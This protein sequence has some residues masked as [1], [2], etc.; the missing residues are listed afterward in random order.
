MYI[1]HVSIACPIYYTV[2][3]EKSDSWLNI[4][5]TSFTYA[6][7]NSGPRKL[8]CGS[9]VVTLT[10]SNNCPPS[11]TLCV[12][13]S[14]NSLIHT[15]ALGSTPEA[16]IFLSSR[17][18]GTKSKAFEKSIIIASILPPLSRES[19]MSRQTVITS[20]TKI[21]TGIRVDLRISS[22]S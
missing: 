3:C 11:R 15:T 22:P 7:N 1:L 6:T 2:V 14:R 21:P 4:F 18:W 19:A 12:R 9:P 16:A 5:Q 20:L 13:P 17:S 8:P 10:S